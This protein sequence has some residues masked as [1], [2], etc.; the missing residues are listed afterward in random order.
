MTYRILR[1]EK[2]QDRNGNDEV[3][4]S[5]EVTDET[6]I[7]NRAEWLTPFETQQLIANESLL[8][9][10]AGQIAQ[11]AQ[12]AYNQQNQTPPQVDVN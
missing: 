1:Y 6:A 12:I 7:Y 3:F 10:F 11:R 2:T 5:I 9:Q 8:D 4:I